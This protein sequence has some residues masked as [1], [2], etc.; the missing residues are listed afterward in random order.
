MLH[1]DDEDAALVDEAQ[2]LTVEIIEEHNNDFCL[3]LTQTWWLKIY[4]HL[5]DR[6]LH[7]L[8]HTKKSGRMIEECHW[9]LPH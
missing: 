2:E 7:V 6:L 5:I 4:V 1:M 8:V 3:Q 9:R